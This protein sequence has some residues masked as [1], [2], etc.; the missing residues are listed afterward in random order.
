MHPYQHLVVDH[1]QKGLIKLKY[2]IYSFIT[3]KDLDVGIKQYFLEPIVNGLPHIV[4]TSEGAAFSLIKSN[5]NSRYDLEKLFPVIK[6]WNA[7]TNYQIGQ[8]VCKNDVIYIALAASIGQTPDTANSPFWIEDDPR[9]Q[10][11]VIHCV[12]IAVFFIT[13]NANLRKRSQ[14]ML[15]AYNRAVG[16]LYDVKK[17]EEN[18]DY[19]LLPI[20][21]MEVRAGSNPKIDHYY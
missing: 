8:H 18:P 5:L 17:G 16:W 15:D 12:N 1:W 11:L 19:P 10:L 9:D 7:Q 13:E 14:E 4:K 21:G 20:G 3:S 2:M 6:E